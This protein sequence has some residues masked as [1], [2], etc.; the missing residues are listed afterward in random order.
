MNQ[1]EM[2][3]AL[4]RYPGRVLGTRSTPISLA[5]LRP[6]GELATGL[7]KTGS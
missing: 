7:T 6:E 3:E 2:P 1:G 4:C 5:A